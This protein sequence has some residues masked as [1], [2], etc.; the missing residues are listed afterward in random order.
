MTGRYYLNVPRYPARNVSFERSWQTRAI[1][2]NY[3]RDTKA[4]WHRFHV[5]CASLHEDGLNY[6]VQFNLNGENP[7][8]L[9]TA[10]GRQHRVSNQSR[11]R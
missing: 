2:G 10:S 6:D 1:E 4:C 3:E 7:H 5:L 11:V 8:V 9:I